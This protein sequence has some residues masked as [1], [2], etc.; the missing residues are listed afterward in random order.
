ML[1]NSLFSMRL[2]SICHLELKGQDTNRSIMKS[3]REKGSGEVVVSQA[4]LQKG[5]LDCSL[6]L[7]FWPPISQLLL[8][9][10]LSIVDIWWC[11][12][13]RH[14]LNSLLLCSPLPDLLL[15]QLLILHVVPQLPPV[16]P[17]KSLTHS[18]ITPTSSHTTHAPCIW[19]WLFH[20][21]ALP[22]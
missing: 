17:N 20:L 9:P 12:S 19:E 14:Y 15:R 8:C 21:C 2:L 6:K 3:Q 16:Q 10:F 7:P 18:L 22:Y 1:I 4:V 11:L 13:I 5:G